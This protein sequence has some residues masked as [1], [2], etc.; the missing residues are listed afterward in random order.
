MKTTIDNEI[1]MRVRAVE[2]EIPPSLDEAFRAALAHTE[3]PPDVNRR[4]RRV[5][6]ISAA[7][8]LLLVVMTAFFIHLHQ[9]LD[10]PAGSRVEVREYAV[11]DAYVDDQPATTY[12]FTTGDNS[13]T[14]IWVERRK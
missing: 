10:N 12:A 13:M 14:V 5:T 1:S 2:E 9:Q 6:I 4:S 8:V 3:T 11:Q 7:A